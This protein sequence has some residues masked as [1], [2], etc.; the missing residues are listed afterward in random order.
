MRL[1]SSAVAASARV[2]SAAAALDLSDEASSGASSQADGPVLL[3]FAQVFTAEP[4][5]RILWIKQGLPAREVEGV[6]RRMGISKER[7]MG[8]LGLARATIDRKVREHKPLSPDESS[9]LL[10]IAHLVGQVQAMVEESGQPDDEGFDA[11]QW[12]AAW[13]DRPLPAL[14]GHRPAELMDTAEG[15]AL[16]ANLLARAHSGAYA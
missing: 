2:R 12:T 16:V 9:R 11:A 6:A 3:R 5:E 13:L 8:T 15:Q 1:S 4:M 10:G 14:D 7:L